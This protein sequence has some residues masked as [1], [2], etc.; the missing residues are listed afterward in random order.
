LLYYDVS[1]DRDGEASKFWSNETARDGLITRLARYKIRIP[2]HLREKKDVT[3]KPEKLF[4]IQGPHCGELSTIN[5]DYTTR[6]YRY[7]YSLPNRGLS[8]VVDTIAKTDTAYFGIVRRAAR[9]VHLRPATPR[10]PHS[11]KIPTSKCGSWRR[12]DDVIMR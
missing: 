10:D 3:V 9:R 2:V 6:S 4:S 5:P 12:L 7:V 8:T 11:P 1:L